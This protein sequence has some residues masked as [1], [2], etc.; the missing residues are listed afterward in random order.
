MAFGPENTLF[1]AKGAGASEQVLLTYTEMPNLL[2]LSLGFLI[3]KSKD[4]KTKFG[5][6]VSFSLS[7]LP[8]FLFFFLHSLLFLCSL[9]LKILSL[10]P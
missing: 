6:T 2:S 4:D 3:C 8:T 1:S 9:P 5:S 10:L 7:S